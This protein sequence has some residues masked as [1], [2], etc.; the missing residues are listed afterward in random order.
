MPIF[1]FE[2]KKC[3]A[4]FDLLINVVNNESKVCP[5]CNSKKIDRIFSSFAVR[6][7]SKSSSSCSTCSSN[8]CS[9]CG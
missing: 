2:C 6:G 1:T 9:S 5:K 7:T 8:K 4:R 3:K